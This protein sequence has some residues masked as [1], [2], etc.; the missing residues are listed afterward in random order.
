MAE[1]HQAACQSPRHRCSYIMICSIKIC[2]DKERLRWWLSTAKNGFNQN[3][4]VQGGPSLHY[5]YILSGTLSRVTT[6]L[7]L[8]RT[9]SCFKC[10]RLG[11]QS[12]PMTCPHVPAYEKRSSSCG[13]NFNANVHRRTGVRMCAYYDNSWHKLKSIAIA[14]G[15]E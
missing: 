2:Y 6:H 8:H 15:I 5:L 10:A 9:R 3:R 14:Y 12:H 7:Q 4:E 13:Q 1:S 11:Y